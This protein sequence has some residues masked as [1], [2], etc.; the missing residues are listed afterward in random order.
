MQ[1]ELCEHCRAL[2]SET[3]QHDGK[4]C[5]LDFECSYSVICLDSLNPKEER[6]TFAAFEQNERSWK[7]WMRTQEATDSVS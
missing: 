7:K 4:F 2:C 3:S 6:E 1:I 5:F